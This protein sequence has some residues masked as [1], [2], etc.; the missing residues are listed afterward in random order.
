MAKELGLAFVIRHI[1][2]DYH[3][4]AKV[5]DQLHVRSHVAECGSTSF[6]MEQKVYRGDK[7]LAKL[8]VVLVAITEGKAV[9]LPPQLRQIF[10]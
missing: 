10:E 5:D 7:L 4:S 8:K 3:A 2:I 9:R 6:T 1:E